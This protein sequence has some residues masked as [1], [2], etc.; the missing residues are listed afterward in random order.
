MI[1]EFTP[2]SIKSLKDLWKADF[3]SAGSAAMKL[4]DSYV[5]HLESHNSIR[6]NDLVIK[7]LIGFLTWKYDRSILQDISVFN[8]LYQLDRCK[9]VTELLGKI[10]LEYV[11]FENF[12]NNGLAF[13]GSKGC[14]RVEI[15]TIPNSLIESLKTKA[16]NASIIFQ[17]YHRFQVNI[18]KLEFSETENFIS[19]ETD[20]LKIK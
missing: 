20:S 13:I 19:F 4:I 3:A 1:K 11:E 16:N 6:I 14:F 10:D 5:D 2:E 8:S 7:D 15:G 17:T 18:K 12:P 9:K